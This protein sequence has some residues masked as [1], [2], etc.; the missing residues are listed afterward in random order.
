MH[1]L[2]TGEVRLTSVNIPYSPGKWASLNAD[3]PLSE[4]DWEAML[5]MLAAMKPG[6]VA[7]RWPPE[8]AD[9]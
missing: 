3:F 2:T 9:H 7:E 8:A 4:S 6:L 1:D 5:A